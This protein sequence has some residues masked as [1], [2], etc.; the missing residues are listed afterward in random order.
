MGAFAQSRR[1]H[2]DMQDKQLLYLKRQDELLKQRIQQIKA[3][4]SEFS[5]KPSQSIS[6]GNLGAL[7]ANST[8]KHLQIKNLS[9]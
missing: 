2:N 6:V 7:R 4:Q 5:A 9:S 8:I 1:V 3:Y